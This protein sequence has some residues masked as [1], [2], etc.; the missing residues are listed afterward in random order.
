MAPVPLEGN[1]TPVGSHIIQENSKGGSISLSLLMDF[2][3]QRTY[4]ELTVLAELYVIFFNSNQY[5][6]KL[7]IVNSIYTFQITSQ[8]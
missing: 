2:I 6:N 7:C 1:Q 3:I 4:H 8:N 5:S